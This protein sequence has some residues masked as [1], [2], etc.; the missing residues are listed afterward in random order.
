MVEG[1]HGSRRARRRCATLRKLRR[2][3]LLAARRIDNPVSCIRESTFRVFS[4]VRFRHAR[5]SEPAAWLGRYGTTHAH[6]SPLHTWPGG[7]SPAVRDGPPQGPVGTQAHGL[8]AHHDGDDQRLAPLPLLFPC[9][10]VLR[11]CAFSA[12]STSHARLQLEKPLGLRTRYFLH[13]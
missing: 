13:L 1:L 11:L 2:Q 6:A 12:G 10:G 9:D 7:H 3:Q 8:L 4:L 5:A